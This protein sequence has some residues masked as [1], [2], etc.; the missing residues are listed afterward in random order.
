VEILIDLTSEDCHAYI[1][2]LVDSGWSGG[3]DMVFKDVVIDGVTCE[4]M[5]Q[6]VQFGDGGADFLVDARAKQ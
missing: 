6:F 2:K 5:L 4:V 1:Q 3:D